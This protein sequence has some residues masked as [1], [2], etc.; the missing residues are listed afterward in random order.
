MQLKDG[1]HHQAEKRRVEAIAK[2]RLFFVLRFTQEKLT[3]EQLRFELR[4]SAAQRH[5]AQD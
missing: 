5:S 1:N 3:S 4:S 2:I